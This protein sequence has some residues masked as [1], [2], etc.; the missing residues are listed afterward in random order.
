MQV[1]DRPR[2]TGAG[3]RLSDGGDDLWKPAAMIEMPVRQ[4]DVLDRREVDRQS[5][6]IVEPDVGI[7]PDVEQQAAFHAAPAARHQYREPVT[8]AAELIEDRLAV[9]AFV[10]AA[11]RGPRGEVHDLRNLG[12]ALIDAR[13]RIG[14]VV[15]HDQNL[16]LV[17]W[18]Y[19]IGKRD[20]AH[21]CGPY[22]SGHFSGP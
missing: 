21:L 6:S 8:G 13:E 19:A 7:G 12:H 5:P 1:D 3:P 20:L 22:L 16:Q 14:L 10:L 9:M 18:Q 15:D 17:E 11:R 2:K 4:E